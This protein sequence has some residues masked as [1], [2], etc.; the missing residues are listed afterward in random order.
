[1]DDRRLSN[2]GTGIGLVFGGALGLLVGVILGTDIVSPLSYGTGGGIIVGA[3]AGRLVRANRGEDAFAVRVVGGCATVGL[4]VGAGVG[5]VSAWSVDAS[6]TS[7]AAIGAGAGIV[8]GLV[9]GGL[10]LS[11]LDRAA[12]VTE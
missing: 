8:H 1:M 10:L 12:T 7:G 9:V 3:L 4:L 5:G 2:L 6:L 11:T